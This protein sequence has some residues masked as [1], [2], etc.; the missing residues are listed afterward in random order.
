MEFHFDHMMRMIYSILIANIHTT[1]QEMG[2]NF[3]FSI[4]PRVVMLCLKVMNQQEYWVAV[5]PMLVRRGQ[6]QM[7]FG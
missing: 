1:C 7:M 5:K 6:M 2:E 4:E 3:I